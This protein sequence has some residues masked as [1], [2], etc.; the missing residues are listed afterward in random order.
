MYKIGVHDAQ[1]TISLEGVG[2][3]SVPTQPKKSRVLPTEERAF[4]LQDPPNTLNWGYMAPNP[5]EG[6]RIYVEVGFDKPRVSFNE[7]S[8]KFMSWLRS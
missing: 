3:A 4:P 6:R 2:D 7:L 8:C 1:A 5:I